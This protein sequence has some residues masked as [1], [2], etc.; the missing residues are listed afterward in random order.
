MRRHWMPA[1]LI[2]EVAE[3][4]G[5]TGCRAPPRRGSRCRSATPRDASACSTATAR[6]AAPRWR[7]GRNEECGL[8]CL[9]HG[10]KFD[11]DGNV[12]EMS[13][14]PAG[15][16]PRAEG[17]STRPIRRTSAGGFVWAYMGPPETMPDVRAAAVGPAGRDASQ[18]RRRSRS[19]CNWA[20]ILEGAIDS[21]HSSTPALV[22]HGAGAR[23]RRE[24]D[25]DDLAASVDRQGA[26]PAGRS[27]PTTASATRRSAGRSRMRRPT[28]TCASPSFVAP[29]T[30]LIPPNNLVQRR[31][32]QRADRRHA[33]DV[34]LHRVERR[35]G[36]RPDAE[37]LAQV[38]AARRSASTST[39]S[40]GRVRNAR[41]PL[42]GRTARR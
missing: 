12:L 15:S 42:P 9:Y 33:H 18:H 17:R 5:A 30:V 31:Q 21:A 39:T 8:R 14:E 40:T 41:Q 13:S 4:D 19:P 29:F 37:A 6:T 38:P 26:A 1:C 32:R 35:A 27:A 20:Q 3:P 25:R 7:S 34:P 28:T 22:R 11:V 10:W 16:Q 2:E 23:R 36:E 24:G